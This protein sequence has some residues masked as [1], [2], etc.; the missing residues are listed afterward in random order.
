[1]SLESI[2][3]FEILAKCELAPINSAIPM[4][5]EGIKNRSLPRMVKTKH[6]EQPI[7]KAIIWFRVKEEAKSPIEQ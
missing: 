2:I 1:M 4:I 6:M 3:P 7:I 5:E